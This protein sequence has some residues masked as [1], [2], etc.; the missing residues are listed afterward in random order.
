MT[1]GLR[2]RPLLAPPVGRRWSLFWSSDEPRY[3]GPGVISPLSPEAGVFRPNQP[4]WPQTNRKDSA[5]RLAGHPSRVVT[6]APA[7]DCA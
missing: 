4:C 2:H 3:G 6:I 5:P 7:G 1:I